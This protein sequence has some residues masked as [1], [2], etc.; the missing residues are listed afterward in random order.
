MLLDAG[1]MLGEEGE[2]QEGVRGGVQG[3][4]DGRRS[5][6]GVGVA[7]VRVKYARMASAALERFIWM[8][9]IYQTQY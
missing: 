7:V 6:V 4:V 5:V 3:V 1:W 9:M 2:K 8:I